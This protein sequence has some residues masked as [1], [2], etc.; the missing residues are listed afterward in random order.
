MTLPADGTDREPEPSLGEPQGP[1]IPRL[2][3][4]GQTWH[5]LVDGAPYL[6]VGGEL[7]NSSPSS[8][9]Y[10]APIWDR[11]ERNGVPSVIGAAS[12]QLVEPEE[13]TFDFT[14]VDDQVEQA[15]S[16]GMRLVLIWFGSYKNADSAYAPTW[17]RRDEERFPRAERDPERL[18][19]GR[20]TIDGPAL[21]VF[22]EELLEADARAFAALL[23]HLREI[24]PGH[25]VIAVQ[26]QNE[27]G[28]LGDSRDRSPLA[29]AAWAAPVPVELL[30]GLA[31]R[32][33]HLH[34]WVADL[35]AR[36]GSRTQGTWAEVF[37][38]G[39]DAEEVFMSWAFS[40]FVGRV[41]EA[42]M[43]E[44]PLP[45]YTNA[46]LGPQPNAPEPG[47]YPSGGPVSRMID[48]W[49]IGAPRL[50]FLSPDIYV[51]D[52]AGAAS[53][54]A[55]AGNAV[56]VPEA[57]PEAGLLFLTLG[58]FRG[59]GFHPFGVEDL[60]DGHELFDAYAAIRGMHGIIAQAQESGA[61]H[62]FSVESGQEERVSFGGYDLTIS[63]PLDTRGMFG[64]G[65][66]SAAEPLTG[67]GLLIHTA[68]DEFL[69][70]A[71]GAWVRFSR[72][73]AVVELDRLTE[74]T[75]RDG[76]WTPGRVL[77]GDE[78]YFM[79]PRDGIRTVRIELLRR[80]RRS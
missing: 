36:H 78:R 53:G 75:Y 31:A 30:S 64:E 42:G 50:A 45:M 21:S 79:F 58:R 28:L 6:S 16:R 48:V 9:A 67:Y 70:V 24:D 11:L 25:T 12:W 22:A 10:M 44:H 80:P 47:Q 23:R 77:N 55:V 8:P 41:A 39:R 5:L 69:V 27:V 68:P 1:G 60:P 46:W 2:V 51:D 73:D 72:P 19:T 62:G 7:H 66:G 17:V 29:E 13:G 32:A 35:W 37:G 74:G 18:L 15:R 54:Y 34:P 52:F 26:V 33:G 59:I 65:T 71:R 14:A 57:R 49:Q 3:R 76:E 4:A 63:G 61:I 20:F 38:E 43:A 40:R 56:F